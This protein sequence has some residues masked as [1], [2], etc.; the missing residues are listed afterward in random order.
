MGMV[1][2]QERAGD[3]DFGRCLRETNNFV[4]DN[5][6]SQF[7]IVGS[8]LYL[9]LSLLCLKVGSRLLAGFGDL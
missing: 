9:P 4:A 5:A 6:K 3:T 8:S 7:R 2:K 1:C